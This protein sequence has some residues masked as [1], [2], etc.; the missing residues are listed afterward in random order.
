MHFN[1]DEQIALE[2]ERVR[3]EPL[4]EEH[5]PALRP[6]ILKDVGLLSLS[7]IKLETAED[8]DH[9]ISVALAARADN[10]RYA[11]AIFDKRSGT[12][13]GSTSYVH[14]SDKDAR[15]EIGFTW[16]GYDYHGTGLNREMKF[17]MLQYAF[18]TLGCMRVEFKA[19]S[20]NTRSRRAMEK[21][22]ATYE[23]T[24]RSHMVLPDG[25]RRNSVCYSILANEWEQISKTIT[26]K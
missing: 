14:I 20:R 5:V 7:T 16:I 11:L 22:G 13:A 24:L 15:L 10:F 19:D 1:F 9:Y 18:E 2:N 21:I 23:G 25:Y 3:L 8:L 26:T 4:R 12:Y 6:V 17:L